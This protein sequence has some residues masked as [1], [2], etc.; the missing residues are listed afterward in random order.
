MSSIVTCE[1]GA[2]V[3]LPAEQRANE[4]RCPRCKSA[5]PTRSG[6]AVR[7][8]QIDV[9]SGAVCPICQ[10][11]IET[12]EACVSCP[13]CG[14]IHHQD[15]WSEIGGCGTYGCQHSP[16]QD[17]SE[18]SVQAPLSAWG[19]TKKC[20]ACGEM[21][22]SIALRCRYCGTD[23]GSVDPLTAADLRQHAIVSTKIDRFKQVVVANFV[24]SLIG[25]LAPLCLIFGLAY[26]LPKRDQLAKCGPIF[27]IMG[28][29]SLGLSGLYCLLLVMFL[30]TSGAH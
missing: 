9:P 23:F 22:K 20:P 3:R 17:K 29:A 18:H 4:L 2:R 21:I 1:C 6:L 28:W 7:S 14:Q 16:A 5:L 25:A 11:S 8:V 30:L 15:C 24:L 19:D 13:G 12:S 26:L 10:S 27:A